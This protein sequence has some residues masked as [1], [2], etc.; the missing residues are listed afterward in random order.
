M[1]ALN[2]FLDQ[3]AAEAATG[4]LVFP[5]HLEMALRVRRALD[6]PESSLDRLATLIRAEPL[7]AARTVALANSVVYNRS[8]RSIT[9]VPSAIAWVG[10]R[11]LSGLTL[12]LIVRQMQELSPEPAHRALASALWDHTAHVAALACVLAHRVTQQ[13]PQVAFFAGIVHEVGGFYLIS[14]A[15]D[16][17]GLLENPLQGW[18]RAGEKRVGRAVL[19]ALDVPP[20]VVDAIEELWLGEMMPLPVT[21]GDTLQLAVRLAHASPLARLSVDRPAGIDGAEIDFALGETTLGAILDDSAEEVDGLMAA[22]QA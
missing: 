18:Y 22:L 1:S 11:A 7:L 20:L 14:R 16:Y 10:L 9:D 2:A 13:D 19:R 12:T 4:T 3:I 8:G 6:D 17:P 5:T 21:L 15:A